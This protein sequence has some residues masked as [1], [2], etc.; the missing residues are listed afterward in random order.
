MT[1]P[2]LPLPPQPE[3]VPWPVPGFDGWPTG[4][5]D[6]PVEGL[7]GELFGDVERFGDTYAAVV[8]QGGRLRSE[9]YGGA[10]PSFELTYAAPLELARTEYEGLFSSRYS[11]WLDQVVDEYRLAREELGA[12]W[13]LPIVDHRRLAGEQFETTYADGTRVTVDY[14]GAG[15][16]RVVRGG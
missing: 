7:V 11:D 5:S 14:R 3:G 10:L 2:L 12:A 8:V 4:A 16:Y 13:R 9:R 15:S 1:D 6:G